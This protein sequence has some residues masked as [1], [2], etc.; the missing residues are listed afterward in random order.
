MLGKFP[1]HIYQYTFGDEM[2]L[3]PVYEKG[4]TT[5]KVF[6][7]EGKWVKYWTGETMQGNTEITV[8]API[9][10]I[11]LFVKQGSIIPMRNY[12]S[13]I[14]KGNNDT[15]IL[16]IYPGD[17]SRFELLEDDGTS[18]DYLKGIFASTIMELKNSSN[19]FVVKI[20][21]LEGNY[22]GMNM[23]RKWI[24]NIH[25]NESPKQIRMNRQKIKFNYNKVTK[26]AIV[27]T[28]QQ[29]VK[30]LLNFNVSY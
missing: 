20:N 9:N 29:S 15:L 14:E 5:Q 2:L 3:A 17:N 23:S 11:P 7:P 13:S 25:C 19:K 1:E 28:S 30:Q 10:Q 21:P 24:L 22:A 4:A 8:A 16:H 18:N 27:E 26:I 12:A 6:L